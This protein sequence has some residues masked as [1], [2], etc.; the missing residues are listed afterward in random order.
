MNSKLTINIVVYAVLVLL[1]WLVAWP[2]WSDVSSF[3][4]EVAL[5]KKTIDLETQ[6]INKLN[7]VNQVLDSQ[8][9]NVERLEQAIPSTESKPELISIM[10]NLSTKNGLRLTG[11]N[12]ESP[13]EDKSSRTGP[14]VTD[15][16]LQK[17]E[18]LIKTLKINIQA[19]GTYAS[20]KS[21]LDAIEKNLRITDVSHISFNIGNK[22]TTEGQSVQVVD[23][24][25]DYTVDMS[26]YI[27]KK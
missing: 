4:S 22:K 21:W 24:I 3:R 8:K 5:K 26:T 15:A 14:R 18:N 12:V 10:E 16:S 7:S 9:A 2:V 1:V 13:V 17:K 20:F 11:V 25:I 27:L 19:S 23:P 6:V